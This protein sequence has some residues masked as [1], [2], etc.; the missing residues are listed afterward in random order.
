MYLKGVKV[1]KSNS[2][3]SRDGN[4]NIDID[5]NGNPVES[6]YVSFV[7]KKD[8]EIIEKDNK[9]Y[10]DAKNA[11]CIPVAHGATYYAYGKPS[12]VTDVKTIEGETY[13]SYYKTPFYIAHDGAVYVGSVYK[14]IDKHI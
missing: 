10:L 14:G 8:C 13:K 12:K 7:R 9:K 6:N 3:I 1:R 4:P 5:L 2:L 11:P